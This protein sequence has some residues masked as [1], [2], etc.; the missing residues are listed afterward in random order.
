[1]GNKGSKVQGEIYLISISAQTLCENS[2][3]SANSDRSQSTMHA[4]SQADAVIM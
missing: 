1:M 2:V 4:H 3:I